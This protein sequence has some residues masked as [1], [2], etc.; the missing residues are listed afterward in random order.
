MIAISVQ[1]QRPSLKD[2]HI[3]MIR[4]FYLCSLLSYLAIRGYCVVCSTS[5][6]GGGQSRCRAWLRAS[7]S[8]GRAPWP[9]STP[10]TGETEPQCRSAEPRPREQPQLSE[11][12][13]EILRVGVRDDDSVA[14]EVRLSA[15]TAISDI[16]CDKL[17]RI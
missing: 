14:G 7:S 10:T 3:S 6:P 1:I 11:I 8:S 12:E 15:G 17:L 16:N 5:P 13:G 2:P 4:V 9:I